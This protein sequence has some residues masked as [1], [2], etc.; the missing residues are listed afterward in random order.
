MTF[1]ALWAA[2]LVRAMPVTLEG[3]ASGTKPG[4][5]SSEDWSLSYQLD[6]KSYQFKAPN[7]RVYAI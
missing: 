7:P 1:L 3:P 4:G 5:T 6:A 2:P